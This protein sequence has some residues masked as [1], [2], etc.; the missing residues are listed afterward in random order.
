MDTLILAALI[1]AG[2]YALN[3]R[4][5]RRRIALLGRHLSNYQ[6]EKLMENLLEGYLRALGEKDEARRE[7]IWQLLITT[8]QQL[9]EQFQRFSADFSKVEPQ[10]A[11]VSRLPVALPFA[12]QLF[13]GASFDLRQ[14]LAIH[15]QGIARGVR[16]ESGLSARDKAYTLTAELLLMQHTCHWF[17]K[18]K[19]IASARM[20]ARHRTPHAQ[21]VDSVSSET[22]RAYRALVEA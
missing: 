10:R 8:E 17:C 12:L 19:A 2:L 5:Q 21:L 1:A 20:L 15:A 3:A 18:S 4:E 9:A 14:A 22:R 11:R 6:I 13:P 16:N 7:Q